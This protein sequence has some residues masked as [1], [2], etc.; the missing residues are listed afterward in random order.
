MI[1]V[2]MTDAQFA[3]ATQR[4]REHG[5]E[6]SG[7]SGTLSQQGV[8]ARYQHADGKLTIEILDKPFFMPL[9]MIESRMK[10]YIEQS[11]GNHSSA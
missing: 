10:S 9:S 1:E 11:I 3:T 5:I 2:P 4:L 8:T 6:L 7:P